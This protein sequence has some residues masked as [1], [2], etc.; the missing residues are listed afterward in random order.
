MAARLRE[1]FQI[2]DAVE[3]HLGQRASVWQAGRVVGFDGPGVWVEVK[4][5]RWFVTNGRRIRA[6][7]AMG[8]PGRG[9]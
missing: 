7:G 2:G 3:I 1:R 4:G 8:E 6:Q 9:E 5:Q